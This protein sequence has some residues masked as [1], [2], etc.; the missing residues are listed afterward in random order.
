MSKS[1]RQEMADVQRDEEPASEAVE[2]PEPLPGDAGEELNKVQDR[3]L[4]LQAELENQRQRARR[5]LEDQRRYANLPL[6]RDLLPVLDNLTRAIESA[7]KSGDSTGLLQGVELLAQQL[8]TTL[9]GHG[10][11]PIDALHQPFDPHRHEAVLQQ[12]SAEHPPGVVMGVTQNGYLLHDRVIRPAQ[13]IVSSAPTSGE[14][15]P[16]EA[17]S[18]KEEE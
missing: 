6:L 12:P 7:E 18:N 3:I 5:E 14:I 16:E 11:Q 10:C 15:H 1:K 13:V 17:P 2:Q 4:R 9:A 8:K